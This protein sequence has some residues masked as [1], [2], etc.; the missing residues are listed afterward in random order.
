MK[1]KEHAVKYT[2]TSGN[3]GSM[4]VTVDVSNDLWYQFNMEYYKLREMD[5]YA[6]YKIEE[7]VELRG[8]LKAVRG[9]NEWKTM[10]AHWKS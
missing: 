2:S 4:N 5:Y 3:K 10:E 8:H 6:M 7:F 9:T 1:L